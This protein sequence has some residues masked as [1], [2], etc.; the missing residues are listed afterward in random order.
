MDC[1][2]L[3]ECFIMMQED[4]QEGQVQEVPGQEHRGCSAQA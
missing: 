2:T 3:V 4:H 1:K